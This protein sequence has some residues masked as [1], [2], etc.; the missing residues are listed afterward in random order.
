MLDSLGLNEE[1]LPGLPSL[2]ERFQ[3]MK[4]SPVMPV[5]MV[6]HKRKYNFW[7]DSAWGTRVEIFLNGTVTEPAKYE[8]PLLDWAEDFRRMIQEYRKQ[9]LFALQSAMAAE[10]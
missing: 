4:I 10:R 6:I 5:I 2:A 1:D 8:Y 3:K 9:Q 7:V